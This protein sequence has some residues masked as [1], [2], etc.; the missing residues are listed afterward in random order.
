MYLKKKER[1]WKDPSAVVFFGR[2]EQKKK[3]KKQQGR[4]LTFA[5]VASLFSFAWY[6]QFGHD[7]RAS[8]YNT[9]THTGLSFSVYNN[10]QT[11]SNSSGTNNA[12]MSSYD[13]NCTAPQLQGFVV[14]LLLLLFWGGWTLI[15]S[16]LGLLA[17]PLLR[18]FIAYL[19]YKLKRPST[20]SFRVHGNEARLLL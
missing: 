4:L 18:V 17:W 1:K 13:G 15:L 20:R 16:Q 10:T 12:P 8:L 2:P 7:K 14:S 6:H 3:T 19:S 5:C 11:F 9:H